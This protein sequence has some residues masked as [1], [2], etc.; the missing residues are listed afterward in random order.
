[1]R[2]TVCRGRISNGNSHR[3]MGRAGF[4]FPQWRR[5]TYY[6]GPLQTNGVA[7]EWNGKGRVGRLGLCDSDASDKKNGVQLR[8]GLM[9]Y[10]LLMAPSSHAVEDSVS[11]VKAG[12]ISG[13][14]TVGLMLGGVGLI[15]GTIL[16]LS[17]SKK[18]DTELLEFSSDVISADIK[19]KCEDYKKPETNNGDMDT[20]A[21]NEGTITDESIKEDIENKPGVENTIS[22]ETKYLSELFKA[23]IMVAMLESQMAIKAH[24]LE[25]RARKLIALEKEQEN[26]AIEHEE[27]LAYIASEID[28]L[29][30]MLKKKELQL[31]S[32]QSELVK[33][34]M[35]REALKAKVLEADKVVLEAENVQK[36]LYNSKQ[37]QE[38]LEKQLESRDRQLEASYKDQNELLSRLETSMSNAEK[39][40]NEL[41]EMKSEYE[42][43]KSALDQFGKEKKYLETEISTLKSKYNAEF[44]MLEKDLETAQK[45][46]HEEKLSKLAVEKALSNAESEIKSLCSQ[47]DIS[48]EERQNL[49]EALKEEKRKVE[50]DLE[51]AQL[52]MKDAKE[53]LHREMEAQAEVRRKQ[54][55]IERLQ[56]ELS[57]A[58]KKILF[59]QEEISKAENEKKAETAPKR[60]RGRPRKHP[61]DST[62]SQSSKDLKAQSN[63][64]KTS[65]EHEEDP[66]ITSRKS[67]S[68]VIDITVDS[69]TK[70]EMQVKLTEADA[71]TAQALAAVEEANRRS[72]EIRAEAALLVET[73]EDRAQEEVNKAEAEVK[74]LKAQL[75]KL[76]NDSIE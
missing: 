53:A 74:R 45:A 19:E 42:K 2:Y 60:K 65:E 15:I 71:A 23:R 7:K 70:E 41:Q 61:V 14:D 55:A 18:M 6:P 35:E 26:I 1:M 32:L 67:G 4:A 66:R 21:Y 27:K 28:S 76:G 50:E 30:E 5:P 40:E 52:A 46:L 11:V 22:S 62:S 16:G 34:R 31:E 24:L 68:S 69:M 36:L 54:E 56:A 73:V 44:N 9:V 47:L 57:S 58:E 59:L 17:F 3:M 20:S 13:L 51:D 10:V 37:M 64:G 29:H 72:F 63:E 12:M 38:Q 8:Y 49:E 33:G 48:K 25:Q 75:E 39:L 43:G